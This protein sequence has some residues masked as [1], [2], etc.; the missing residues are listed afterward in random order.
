MTDFN[1]LFPNPILVDGYPAHQIIFTDSFLREN[2]R[3]Q[4]AEMILIV[5]KEG[6]IYHINYM[7]DPTKYL[8]YLPIIQKMITTFKFTS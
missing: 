8:T 2:V 3:H 7:A 4:L 6:Q 5:V 1:V